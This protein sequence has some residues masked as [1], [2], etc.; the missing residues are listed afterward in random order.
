[1]NLPP[2]D[3]DEGFKFLDAVEGSFVGAVG[4]FCFHGGLE[5]FFIVELGDGLYF[6]DVVELFSFLGTDFLEVIFLSLE[7]EEP[8]FLG[9]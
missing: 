6:F 4:I 1:M 2:P 8:T 7:S 3:I 5:G 9:L